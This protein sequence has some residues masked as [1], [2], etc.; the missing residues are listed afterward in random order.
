MCDDEGIHSQRMPL[1]ERGVIRNSLYDLETAGHA[2][3]RSTGNANRNLN[4][5][6]SPGIS[7][8]IMSKGDTSLNDMLA[9][10]KS[11]IVVKRLLGTGQ[12]NILGGDFNTNVLLEYRVEKGKIIGR[13]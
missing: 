10:T 11:G 8:T 1:V 12:S 2:N 7:V 9:Y 5:L 4:R 3:T 6:P 13:L